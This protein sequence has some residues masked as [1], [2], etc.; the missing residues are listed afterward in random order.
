LSSGGRITLKEAGDVV[1]GKQTQPTLGG[2][3][4]EKSLYERLGGVNAIAMVVDRF[5]DE[6]VRIR[7]ST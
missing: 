6:I 2:E 1:D 4:P 3:M 5:S 7:S